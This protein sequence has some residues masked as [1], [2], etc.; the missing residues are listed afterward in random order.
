MASRLQRPQADRLV[1]RP[2]KGQP[3]QEKNTCQKTGLRGTEKLADSWKMNNVWK[4]INK[5]NKNVINMVFSSC[6]LMECKQN[7][8]TLKYK[9]T[10]NE[11]TWQ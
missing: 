8:I 6:P 1:D 9:N 10:V 3:W 2:T 5:M 11:W 4:I 7:L